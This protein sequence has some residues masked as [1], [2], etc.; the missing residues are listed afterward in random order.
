M[1]GIKKSST[2]RVGSKGDKPSPRLVRRNGF[3]GGRI[4]VFLKMRM[5]IRRILNRLNQP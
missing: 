4:A 3:Q 5:E 1:Q 2:L